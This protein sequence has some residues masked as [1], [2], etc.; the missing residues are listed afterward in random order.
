MVEVR[1][2]C[3]Q[4]FTLITFGRGMEAETY[5]LKENHYYLVGTK[6]PFDR[7][8]LTHG[9]HIGDRDDSLGDVK[10]H[11]QHDV[12]VRVEDLDLGVELGLVQGDRGLGNAG[13]QKEL[14]VRPEGRLQLQVRRHRRLVEGRV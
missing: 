6:I 1:T 3:N 9:E 5:H 2:T 13:V 7:G 11:V 4:L 8:S 12:V 14:Q 10:P